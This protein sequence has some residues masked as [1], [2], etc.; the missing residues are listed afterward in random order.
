MCHY[1]SSPGAGKV[2]QG[3]GPAQGWGDS[4]DH[5]ALCSMTS[6]LRGQAGRARVSAPRANQEPNR[7]WGVSAGPA[8][9]AGQPRTAPLGCGS[10]G[11]PDPAHLSSCPWLG[12]P[13][14]RCLLRSCSGTGTPPRSGSPGG[15]TGVRPGRAGPVQCRRREADLR[16]PGAATQHLLSPSASSCPLATILNRS[17]GEP[18]QAC[19]ALWRH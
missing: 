8:T 2:R 17:G 16:G 18:S 11:H 19:P 12:T 10:P 15:D 4:Q 5:E 1:E 7:P 6:R 9:A 13:R 3:H 14:R